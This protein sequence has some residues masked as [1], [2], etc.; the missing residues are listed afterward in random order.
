MRTPYR[1]ITSCHQLQAPETAGPGAAAPLPSTPVT[2]HMLL[3]ANLIRVEFCTLFSHLPS[4]LSTACSVPQTPI[5]DAK[6]VDSQMPKVSRGREWEGYS[7][8]QL[9]TEYGGVVSSPTAEVEFCKIC[10][11]KKPSDG[12]HFTDVIL[13]LLTC[14]TARLWKYGHDMLS[15]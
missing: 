11:P 1:P 2:R 9:T 14:S 7:L 4:A 6:G 13:Q 3:N 12:T 5:F 8:P 15:A 10:V